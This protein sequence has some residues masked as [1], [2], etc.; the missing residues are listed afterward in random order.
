M[1]MVIDD[2]H[3]RIKLII[4]NIENCHQKSDKRKNK[5][6]KHCCFVSRNRQSL[7][8]HTSKVHDGMGYSCQVCLKEYKTLDGVRCHIRKKHEIVC[9]YDNVMQKCLNCGKTYKRRE[10]L[11]DHIKNK[12]HLWMGFF[13]LDKPKDE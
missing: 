6:C 11:R 3:E 1:T 9:E 13:I 5:K 12:H 10:D 8:N 7:R 2:H 4:N